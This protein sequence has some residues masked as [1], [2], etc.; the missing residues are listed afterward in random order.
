[1][2]FIRQPDGLRGSLASPSVVDVRNWVLS[3]DSA[4]SMVYFLIHPNLHSLH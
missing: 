1:L 3:A 2:I 4:D